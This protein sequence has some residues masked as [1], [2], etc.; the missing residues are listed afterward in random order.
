MCDIWSV[1]FVIIAIINLYLMFI[2]LFF[3]DENKCCE[4]PY[5]IVG[6]VYLLRPSLT[7]GVRSGMYN[8]EIMNVG[9]QPWEQRRHVSSREW[10]T[11]SAADIQYNTI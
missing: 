3:G 4:K 7:T 6:V 1:V 5:S 8:A 9:R 10:P 11:S 2:G